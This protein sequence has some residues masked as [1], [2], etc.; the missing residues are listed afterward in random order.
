MKCLIYVLMVIAPMLLKAQQKFIYE[1]TIEYER[2]INLHR[3]VSEDDERSDWFKNLVKTM[4]PFHSS[5]FTLQFRENQTMYKIAGE[6][7]SIPMPWLMGPAKEN[8]VFTSFN[9]HTRTSY[10][11]VFETKFLVSDSLNNV[12]W[13][14]SDEKRTIAGLECRKAVG[15]ICDSVYVVAFYTD[16]IPVSGGPES[17]EGLPGM[18]LGLAIPRLHTTWFATKVQ[19]VKPSDKDFSMTTKGTK[20]DRTKLNATLQASLK[21]WGKDAV[22]Y[23]WWVML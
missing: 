18:I 23:I 5:L 22:R 3:Q 15:R 10:K 13:K 17:F 16:E 2:R 12:E 8:T 7:P 4:P 6:L 1:G 21:D 11:S 14:I 19:L 20:T 9:N